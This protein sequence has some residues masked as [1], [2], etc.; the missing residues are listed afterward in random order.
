MD[1]LLLHHYPVSDD[2]GDTSVQTFVRLAGDLYLTRQARYVLR[3]N[4]KMTTVTAAD[5]DDGK[6]RMSAFHI[7][8]FIRRVS[9]TKNYGTIFICVDHTLYCI[10]RLIPV[11]PCIPAGTVGVS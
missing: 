4:I 8:F 10:L 7:F 6:Y 11:V 2:F 5:G 1:T 9:T 3:V